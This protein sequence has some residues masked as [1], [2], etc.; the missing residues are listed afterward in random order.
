MKVKLIMV[1]KVLRLNWWIKISIMKKIVKK[2]VLVKPKRVIP[3][4]RS[5]A[6]EKEF[7]K[8]LQELEDPKN[9]G[10]GS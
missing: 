1:K 2:K 5:L 9:I 7:E 10:S 8:I 6:E 4:K 3:K